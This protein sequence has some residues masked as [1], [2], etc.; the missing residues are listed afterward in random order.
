[1]SGEWLRNIWLLQDKLIFLETHINWACRNNFK[2][3]WN[4]IGEMGY[5]TRENYQ[6]WA[7]KSQK[8]FS[9]GPHPPKNKPNNWPWTFQ[10]KVKD[11]VWGF[12]FEYYGTK[13]KTSFKITYPNFIMRFTT[14]WSAFN[15]KFRKSSFFFNV[16][17]NLWLL[18]K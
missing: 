12:L 18:G 1:M 16:I 17:K 9:I 13:L 8:V 15:F 5:V 4:W 10:P 7:C 2:V 11:L 3:G 6:G 14:L